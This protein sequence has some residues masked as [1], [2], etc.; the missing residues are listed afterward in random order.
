[1]GFYKQ[2]ESKFGNEKAWPGSGRV[3]NGG[4][5]VE[6][7]EVGGGINGFE[8]I[9]K[10]GVEDVVDASTTAKVLGGDFRR[11]TVDGRDE[12]GSEA[13]HQ[14]QDERATVLLAGEGD[15]AVAGKLLLCLTHQSVQTGFD[16]GEAFPN[17]S[18]QSCVEALC[19]VLSAAASGH[20]PV[21][22]MHS[23]KLPLGS[24]CIG[25]GLVPLNV[26]LRA[27]DDADEAQ[28][29]GVDA[30]RENVESVC[31]VIHEIQ[32]GE[33]TDGSLSHGVDMTG[34][35]QCLGVDQVLVS[36][37]DG[38]DDA[39]GFGNVLGDEV[40]C[41]LLNVGGLVSDGH[42]RLKVRGRDGRSGGWTG[43]EWHGQY[44]PWSDRADQRG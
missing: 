38:K 15:I 19:K 9:A 10:H 26:L 36:G 18:H 23:E 25:Q 20:V 34:E 1:M 22:G 39:V 29:Q 41:L 43:Q 24:K 8:R 17:V 44:A 27:V 5:N 40:P 7:G 37:R 11:G 32:L 2:V 12:G 28:F 3:S 31:S 42:L 35:L 4:A 6:Y 16:V 13:G 30:A 14:L 33:D 21:S